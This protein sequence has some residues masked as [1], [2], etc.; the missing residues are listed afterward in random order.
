MD[1]MKVD[2]LREAFLAAMGLNPSGNRR[3][4]SRRQSRRIMTLARP[5]DTDDVKND[6]LDLVSLAWPTLDAEWHPENAI[7]K[8][9]DILN[10]KHEQIGSDEECLKDLVSASHCFEV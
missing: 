1:Q 8:L 10:F 2:E 3:E 4:A 7:Q 6:F 5:S 9:V